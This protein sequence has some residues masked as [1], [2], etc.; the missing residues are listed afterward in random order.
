MSLQKKVK[1]VLRGEMKRLLRIKDKM[2]SQKP[3]FIRMNSWYLVRIGNSWKKPWSLDNKIRLERK[4]FPKKVK[5][6]YRKPRKVRNLH[7]SGFKEIIIHNPN[8]V[9]KVDS[10]KY[11]IRIASTVSKRKRKKILRRAKKYGIRVLN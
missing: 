9:V 2:T 8:E 6:G 5:V 3:N 11:A 10:K 4:G 7:P 1:P